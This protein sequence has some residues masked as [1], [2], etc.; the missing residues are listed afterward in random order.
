[1]KKL[2]VDGRGNVAVWVD[3]FESEA[4]ME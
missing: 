2:P 3:T 1:M 4:A